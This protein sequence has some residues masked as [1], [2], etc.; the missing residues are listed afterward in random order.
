MKAPYN[1]IKIHK[2]ITDAQ[3]LSQSLRV[4]S[5]KLMMLY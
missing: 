4:N 5:S 2:K 3:R 1:E